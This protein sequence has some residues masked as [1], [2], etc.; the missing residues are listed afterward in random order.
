MRSGGIIDICD[1]HDLINVVFQSR[2]L[3]KTIARL[4]MSGSFRELH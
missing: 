2:H 1:G 4:E 3:N